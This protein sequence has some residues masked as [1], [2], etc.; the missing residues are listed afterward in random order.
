MWSK[1]VDCF[2]WN[3]DN[4]S[5]LIQSVKCSVIFWLLRIQC[6]SRVYIYVAKLNCEQW[7]EPYAV[8]IKHWCNQ[9][10]ITLSWL[11]HSLVVSSVEIGWI[12]NQIKQVFSWLN[13]Q[14][15]IRNHRIYVYQNINYK[16]IEAHIFCVDDA[17]ALH[18]T[19]KFINIKAI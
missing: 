15:V 19:L 5:Y 3:Q 10:Y 16:V 9:Y 11:L 2:S 17:F 1:Y 4:L 6:F 7:A 18:T 13:F 8:F 12:F 14:L